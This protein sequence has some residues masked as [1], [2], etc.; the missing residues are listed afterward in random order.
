MFVA[1]SKT[2]RI[3]GDGY[4]GIRRCGIEAFV[5]R[6]SGEAQEAGERSRGV[7]IQGVQQEQVFRL[8]WRVIR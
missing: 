2:F 6:N 8:D 5:R 7:S 1:A 3:Q 4:A